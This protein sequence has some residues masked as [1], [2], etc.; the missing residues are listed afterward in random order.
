LEEITVSEKLSGKEILERQE[1]AEMEM[2][3]EKQVK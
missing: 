2:V 3:Q 1:A